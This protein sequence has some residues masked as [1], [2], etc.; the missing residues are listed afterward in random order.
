MQQLLH[1]AIT[2]KPNPCYGLLTGSGNIVKGCLPVTKKIALASTLTTNTGQNPSLLGVYLATD[3]NGDI[4]LKL[5]A[6][7]K[8]IKP[9]HQHKTA[10]YYLILYLDH[11]GRIDARIYHNEQLNTVITLCMQEDGSPT[12][13]Q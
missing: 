5:L 12:A 2:H 7:L 10:F 6:K 4:D 9:P 11:K 3:S 1:E 8:A 13:T